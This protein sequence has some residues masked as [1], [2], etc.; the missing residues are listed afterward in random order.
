MELKWKMKILYDT[1]IL[2]HIND[3]KEL[4]PNLQS[5]LAI[6]R[7]HGHQ[8][9]I[10]PASQ[11]DIENDNDI[12]RR[13]VTLSKLFGYPFLPSPPKPDDNF[14]SLVGPPTNSHDE[15]DNEILYSL[16]KNLV[17]FLI[18]EDKGI[19]NKASLLNLDDRVFSIEAALDYFNVMYQR[20]SPSH[21]LL[22][23]M[24]AHEIN[25]DQSFFDS[26]K[27]DYG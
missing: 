12:G 23:K 9:V 14:I 18:T 8:E 10:H 13:K 25:I 26:L 21:S 15:N 19:K 2:I 16:Q 3:P 4:S 24:Y 11:K 7:E 22:R 6:I 5:L 17:D 20:F 1:N 27:E